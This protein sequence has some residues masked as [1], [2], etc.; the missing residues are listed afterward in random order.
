MNGTEISTLFWL[1]GRCFRPRRSSSNTASCTKKAEMLAFQ[2]HKLAHCR[3]LIMYYVSV[4]GPVCLLNVIHEKMF[5]ADIFQNGNGNSAVLLNGTGNGTGVSERNGNG[6]QHGGVA[7]EY[8]HVPVPSVWHANIAW[9]AS[10]FTRSV[11]RRSDA[12]KDIHVCSPTWPLYPLACL[13]FFPPPHSV[14]FRYICCIFPRYPCS[15][16]RRGHERFCYLK[17]AGDRSSRMT[18]L[19]WPLPF[20]S[21]SGPSPHSFCKPQSLSRSRKVAVFQA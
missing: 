19:V 15:V 20:C 13:V 17:H 18:A 7:D 1:L 10:L 8:Y 5:R 21:G 16:S 12:F 11:R 6:E 3:I 4:L 9:R 2:S 14:R